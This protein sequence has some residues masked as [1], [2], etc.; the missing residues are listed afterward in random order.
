MHGSVAGG[1]RGSQESDGLNIYKDG[2]TNEDEVSEAYD[3]QY[4]QDNDFCDGESVED[5]D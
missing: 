5:H 1:V 2:I 4:D 3:Y